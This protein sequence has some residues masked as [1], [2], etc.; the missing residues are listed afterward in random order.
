M[1]IQNLRTKI[2]GCFTKELSILSNTHFGFLQNFQFGFENES[3]MIKDLTGNGLSTRGNVKSNLIAYMSTRISSSALHADNF[4]FF[5]K[6]KRQEFS[7][8]E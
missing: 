3:N 4:E 1:F 5:V 6:A 8:E 2:Q 7:Q